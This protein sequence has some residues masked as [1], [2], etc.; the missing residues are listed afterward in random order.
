VETFYLCL[1]IL[2]AVVVVWFT[3][4]VVYRLVQTPR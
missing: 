4:Y 3:A 2:T 1:L